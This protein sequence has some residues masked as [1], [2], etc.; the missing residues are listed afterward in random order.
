M[1]MLEGLKNWLLGIGIQEETVVYLAKIIFMTCVIIL[2]IVAD[3][4]LRKIFVKII[5]KAVKKTKSRLDDLLV[6]S[7]LLKR[8]IYFAP[9]LIIHFGVEVI[10][11]EP[12]ASLILIKRVLSSAFVFIG[13]YAAIAALNGIEQFY[14]NF[15]IAK[16]APIKGYIQLIKIFMFVIGMVFIISSLINKSPWGILSSIGAMTAI[17]IL[18]FKDSIL[19]LVSS[20]QINANNMVEIGDWIQI[21]KYGAD[22]AVIDITLNTVKV[23]NWDKTI[24]TIPTYA[25]VADS[26]K[27]WRGMSESGG[28]SS[29]VSMGVGEAFQ[30]PHRLFP[31][32][33]FTRQVS[34]LDE[35]SRQPGILSQYLHG[36]A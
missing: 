11:P 2:S 18:V 23:Q 32:C 9:L 15:E 3:L 8:L 33:L 20:I 28:K 25:L 12:T 29:V 26:F 4:V 34:Q 7:R 5:L 6:S 35:E 21:P 36:P 27:N 16:K 13:M 10:F 24:T 22:G 30:C 31:V 14:R 19:G 1:A 17:I